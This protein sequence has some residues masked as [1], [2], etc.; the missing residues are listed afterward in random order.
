MV[1]EVGSG[2][3]VEVVGPGRTRVEDIVG[4]FLADELETHT[5]STR[6]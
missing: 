3:D 6:T 4:D 5:K 2:D 1:F